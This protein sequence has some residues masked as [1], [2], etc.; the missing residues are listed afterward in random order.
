MQQLSLFGEEVVLTSIDPSQNRYRYYFLSIQH[1]RSDVHVIE[2]RWGRMKQ[3]RFSEWSMSRK[4]QIQRKVTVF[5]E[6]DN[7]LRSFKATL[8]SKRRKGYVVV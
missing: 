4:R 6:A 8:K 3:D 1:V 2:K 7:A 5:S